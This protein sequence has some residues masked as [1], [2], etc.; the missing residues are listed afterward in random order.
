[1]S[2]LFSNGVIYMLSTLLGRGAIIFITIFTVNQMSSFESSEL[3]LYLSLFQ[4]FLVFSVSGLANIA[5]KRVVAASQSLQQ[6]SKVVTCLFMQAIV[7][8]ALVAVCY[9]FYFEYALERSNNRG[10]VAFCFSLSL[11]VQ[12]L[13]LLVQSI[14]QGLGDFA[15]HFYVSIFLFA[16]VAV[17]CLLFGDEVLN[18]AIFFLMSNFAALLFAGI[19]FLRKHK[20]VWDWEVSEFYSG[21]NETLPIMLS[22]SVVPLCLAYGVG[23]FSIVASAEQSLFYN[24]AQQW[25]GVISLV[26][27]ALI[28]VMLPRL[29]L[30][31]GGGQG[32]EV[33]VNMCVAIFF[34]IAL[35][36]GGGMTLV[37]FG[38]EALYGETFSGAEP[39]FFV[40]I[41][42]SALASVN[43]VMGT[44][45][46]VNAS[47]KVMILVNLIWALGYLLLLRFLLVENTAECFAIILLI[48]YI[49]HAAVQCVFVR[50]LPHVR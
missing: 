16:C 5:I 25:R 32:A 9:F 13:I 28:Q 38:L 48:S 19:V 24:A 44:Y 47:Y 8:S 6:F 30:T 46:L 22:S 29:F 49:V 12:C 15:E 39:V 7:L 20:S 41:A 36:C 43:S 4:L 14:F 35:V 23:Y 33:W 26:P 42:A 11:V 50:Q 3:V 17:S 31:R 10:F 21:I 18:V 2:A 1:M 34:I 37:F 45:F 40:V 27:A